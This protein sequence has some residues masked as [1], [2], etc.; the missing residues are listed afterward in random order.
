MVLDNNCN[1]HG[2]CTVQEES[3]E[4]ETDSEDEQYGRRLLKPVFVPKESRE[5]SLGLDGSQITAVAT[6]TDQG[7]AYPSV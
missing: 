1:P 6:N 4:Y 7:T 3:S 2:P 5:V